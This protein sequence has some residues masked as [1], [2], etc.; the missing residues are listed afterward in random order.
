MLEPLRSRAPWKPTPWILWVGVV[1][2][3]LFLWLSADLAERFQIPSDSPGDG[4][5]W[6]FI[7][8]DAIHGLCLLGYLLSCTAIG[9][10]A[11]WKKIRGGAMLIWF[12]LIWSIGN[13]W[14]T[15]V[16]FLKSD[17]IFDPANAR[18]SWT[19][20]ES[21][22]DDPLRWGWLVIALALTLWVQWLRRES[23][24]TPSDD[25]LAGSG[26]SRIS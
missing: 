18:T 22:M 10:V 15:M 24:N 12:G 8:R 6:Y 17:H 26:D 16:I 20:F 23:G 2:Y 21:Y 19:T 25:A 5:P 3:A 14:E 13:V 4:P 9:A 7:R 1:L 11:M